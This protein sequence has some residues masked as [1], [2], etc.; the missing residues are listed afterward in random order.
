MFGIF[1]NVNKRIKICHFK[2]SGQANPICHLKFYYSSKILQLVSL[3]QQRNLYKV[4]R[5]KVLENNFSF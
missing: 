3:E 2:V 4:E 5:G 1:N